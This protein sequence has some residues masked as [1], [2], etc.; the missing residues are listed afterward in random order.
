MSDECGAGV[1]EVADPM[2]AARWRQRGLLCTCSSSGDDARERR[3]GSA[4]SPLLLHPSG[5]AALRLL[6]ELDPVLWTPDSV[7]KA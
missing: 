5:A 4:P 3:R 7:S 1:A 6:H 2:G